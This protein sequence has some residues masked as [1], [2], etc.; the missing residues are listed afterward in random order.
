MS[1]IRLGAI[2]LYHKYGSP[3]GTHKPEPSPAIITK[4]NSD[5]TV[6]VCVFNPNGIYFNRSEFS[7]DGLPAPGKLT[8][9]R[10]DEGFEVY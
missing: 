1:M 3:D 6:N 2:V 9:P 10:T 5:G 7:L 8:W 4:V